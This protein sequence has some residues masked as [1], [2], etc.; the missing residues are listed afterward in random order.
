MASGR[1]V[2][3]A[4]PIG[5]LGDLS[6]RALA[7][8]R[9]ADV[10]AAED[11]RRTRALLTHAEITAGRR[12]TALHA[13]NE[14]TRSAGLV[15]RII[16]GETVALVTDAGTPGISDPGMYL[17]QACIAA[18]CSVEVVPGPSAHTAALVLSG[19]P[20]ERC[21]FEGFIP[22][23]GGGRTQALSDIK[24]ERRTIV[25]YEA[26]SRINALLA[27]LVVACGDD[28]R[29]A[30]AR[31]ITKIHEEVVRGSLASVAAIIAAGTPRGEYVVVLEG[32]VAAPQA[33]ADKIS[34]QAREELLNS[35]ASDSTRVIAD[36]IASELGVSRRAAYAA[37]LAEKERTKP[38]REV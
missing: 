13:H 34:A 21:V 22:R 9:D 5:N 25:I 4:T 11:T 23:R 15:K 29:V 24:Q 32:Q 8:L 27:D 14:R 7:A 1:L 10:I 36:R 19:L 31:E 12:L 17:V 28:R 16:E 26:P 2:V 37:V 18:Q 38:K 35:P 20:T 3:V 6:L 30:V 33:S